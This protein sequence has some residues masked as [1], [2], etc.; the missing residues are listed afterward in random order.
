MNTTVN[1][2]KLGA[3]L[4]GRSVHDTGDAVEPWLGGLQPLAAPVSR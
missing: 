2:T 4:R 3:E 1:S